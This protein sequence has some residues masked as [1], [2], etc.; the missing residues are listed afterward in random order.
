MIFKKKHLKEPETMALRLVLAR[1]LLFS[2]PISK[3]RKKEKIDQLIDSL[4][5]LKEIEICKKKEA[6][7]KTRWYI[8]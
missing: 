3:V 1:T 4:L 5:L 2:L 6:E 8:S 7:K